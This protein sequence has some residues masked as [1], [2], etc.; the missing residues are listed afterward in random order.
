[1]INDYLESTAER[2]AR[3]NKDIQTMFY[4]LT[5]HGNMPNLVFGE[6]WQEDTWKGDPVKM[7]EIDFSDAAW[8]AT[9]PEG[10]SNIQLTEKAEKV[11]VDG[12]LYIIRDGKMFNANG[13]Q[14]K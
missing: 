10:I 6:L 2:R 9:N 1:M 13:A 5:R 12:V 11:V 3:R 8:K 14:V 7:I 4:Q